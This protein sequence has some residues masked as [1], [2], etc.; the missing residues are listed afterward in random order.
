M[1]YKS[2]KI[3]TH[4]QQNDITAA[5]LFIM[6]LINQAPTKNF[7]EENIAYHASVVC[8]HDYLTQYFCKTIREFRAQSAI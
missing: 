4:F 6:K 3:R 1:N 2:R 7:V 8:S 5:D